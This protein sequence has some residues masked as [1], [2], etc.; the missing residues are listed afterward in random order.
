[1]KINDVWILVDLPEGVK[2]I[3][4]KWVFKRKRGVDEK[5]KIYKIHLVAKGY[6]QHYS[7]DYDEIFSLVAMLKSIQII[8]AIAAYLNYEVWQIDVKIAF[9]K[10]RAE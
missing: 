4:C 7:V 2:S 9:P 6:H 8:L 10:W 5:V 1:M 3:G